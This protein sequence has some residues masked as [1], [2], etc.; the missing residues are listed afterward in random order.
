MNAAIAPTPERRNHAAG[1]PEGGLEE[2]AAMQAGV[3]RYAVR[4]PLLIDRLLEKGLLRAGEHDTAVRAR[5]LYEASGLRPDLVGRYDERTSRTTGA[6]DARERRQ[7]RYRAL[8]RA[9]FQDAGRLGL[10]AF[11]ALVLEDRKIPQGLPPLRLA[12][13]AAE[14]QLG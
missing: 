14:R 8:E 2:T 10:A 4:Q 6:D 1:S 3:R 12:L 11:Q 9:I 7:D 13:M 5:T